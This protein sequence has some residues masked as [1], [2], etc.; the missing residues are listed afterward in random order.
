M[1]AAEESLSIGSQDSISQDTIDSLLEET[2]RGKEKPDSLR[3][4]IPLH[5]EV[6]LAKPW[7]SIMIVKTQGE[8]LNVGF[9][10]SKGRSLRQQRLMF[11]R[12][13]QNNEIGI[14]ENSVCV[15]ALM[16]KAITIREYP[17]VP[18]DNPS[19]SRGCPLSIDWEHQLE[20]TYHLDSYENSRTAERRHQMEM[21]VPTEIRSQIL[22][23]NGHSWKEIHVATKVANVARRQRT[24]SIERLPLERVTRGFKTMLRGKKEK[25]QQSLNSSEPLS[26]AILPGAKKEKNAL[27]ISWSK[28]AKGYDL[29]FLSDDE[30]E[31]KAVD[32]NSI[33]KSKSARYYDLKIP[34]DTNSPR[35]VGVAAEILEM[36]APTMVALPAEPTD[37]DSISDRN[38]LSFGN[39][40]SSK[41][42]TI[43]LNETQDKK[44]RK[45]TFWDGKAYH[46]DSGS[47]VDVCCGSG[48]QCVNSFLRKPQIYL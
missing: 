48:F 41:N 9:G 45:V 5:K 20:Q 3:K 33:Y 38:E 15:V 11:R 12:K 7:S 29:A 2:Q 13:I 47:D 14:S 18:G 10:E 27:D 16:Y 42:F 26:D 22:R 21:I 37:S 39:N 28:S 36:S 6:L 25:Q 17:M 31:E 32:M 8:S 40:S 1:S 34:T 35:A 46:S 19:V 23:Q 30:D 44:G 43:N 24:K 4:R